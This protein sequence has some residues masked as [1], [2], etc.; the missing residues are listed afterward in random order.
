[1]VYVG[2]HVHFDFYDNSRRWRGRENGLLVWGA[3]Q[4]LLLTHRFPPDGLDLYAM[5]WS[6]QGSDVLEHMM[7]ERGGPELVVKHGPAAGKPMY[8]RCKVT[9]RMLRHSARTYDRFARRVCELVLDGERVSRRRAAAA[10]P[11]AVVPATGAS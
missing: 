11:A 9:A 4:L 6:R 7:F 8:R 3:I 1:M 10:P 5:A 2:T